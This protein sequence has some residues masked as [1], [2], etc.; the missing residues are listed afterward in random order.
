MTAH[1]ASAPAAVR[2]GGR[3][4]RVRAAVLQ[5]AFDVLVEAG[6]DAMTLPEVARRAGVHPATVYR[7][8]KTKAGLLA[9]AMLDLT[10]QLIPLADTG[11]LRGDL[12]R[13][14]TGTITV[15]DL[16]PTRALLAALA[17]AVEPAPE[18]SRA[19]AEFWALRLDHAR[20][21]VDRAITRGE[22]PA[23]TDPENL[24]ELL[25]GPAYLRALVTGRPRDDQLI[26][27][28]VEHVIAAHQ[29]P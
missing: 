20:T 14:L 4:A 28:T 17:T 19:R 10:A 9:E 16:Q 12:E 24:L 1:S 13:L 2:P 7:R 21:I 3:S 8:W 15:L 11:S 5:A 26:T 18:V 27:S 23:G 22:L 6:Y 25:V 29:R